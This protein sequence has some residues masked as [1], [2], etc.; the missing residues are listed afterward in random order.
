MAD[1]G[2]ITAMR[3]VTGIQVSLDLTVIAKVRNAVILHECSLT[4]R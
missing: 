2:G 3:R 1:I 4:K